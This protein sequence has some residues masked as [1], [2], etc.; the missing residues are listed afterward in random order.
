MKA[1]TCHATNV[2][3]HNCDKAHAQML[4]SVTKGASM[5]ESRPAEAVAAPGTGRVTVWQTW[6]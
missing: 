6:A 1:V 2:A 5:Q 4:S 3:G